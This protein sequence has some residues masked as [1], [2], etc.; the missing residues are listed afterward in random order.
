M[1]V[2]VELSLVN[3]PCAP[4]LSFDVF[5]A[6]IF[7][8]SELP[9]GRM[10]VLTFVNESCLDHFIRVQASKKSAKRFALTIID[11]VWA[12]VYRSSELELLDEGKL[13]AEIASVGQFLIV[14][15]LEQLL[16]CIIRSKRRR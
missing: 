14:L 16:L 8:H 7:F 1:H 2:H 15:L 13:E 4:L 3:L 12:Q 10:P 9:H 5:F 11:H 6:A